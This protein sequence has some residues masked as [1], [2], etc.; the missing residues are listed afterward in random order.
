MKKLILRAALTISTVLCASAV[1]TPAQDRLVVDFESVQYV[2]MTLN[3]KEGDGFQLS[4]SQARELA[5]R[6]N[7]A[8]PIGLCKFKAK[9]IVAVHAK[10][11]ETR[12]FRATEDTI[13]EEN[14]YCFA[15]EDRYIET[16]WKLNQ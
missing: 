16:V 7:Q 4:N 5:K 14:D 13:K 6:W 12:T 9:Y 10:Y 15:M 8:R 11:G 3:G 1:A 2:E